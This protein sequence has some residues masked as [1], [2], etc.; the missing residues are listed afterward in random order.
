MSFCLFFVNNFYS[1]NSRRLLIH[2]CLVISYK[3]RL[4]FRTLY[5]LLNKIEATCPPIVISL[6]SFSSQAIVS[7]L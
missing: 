7:E 4:I 6:P 2:A 1:E 5:Y 3:K